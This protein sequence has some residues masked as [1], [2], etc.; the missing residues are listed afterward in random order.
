MDAPMRPRAVLFLL[1]LVVI[2]VPLAGAQAGQTTFLTVQ[3]SDTILGRVVSITAADAGSYSVTITRNMNVKPAKIG[4]TLLDGDIVTL[5]PG[6]FANLQLVDRPDVTM[7]GGG[8]SGLAARISRAGGAPVTGQ[9]TIAATRS[10]KPVLTNCVGTVEV[11]R[12]TYIEG[13]YYI[14]RSQ[15]I[16]P[17]TV[18]ESLMRG[19]MI[20][21]DDPDGKIVIQLDYSDHPD[22][23]GYTL[24]GRTR[25]DLSCSDPAPVRS[26]GMMGEV[27]SVMESVSTTIDDLWTKFKE[28]LRGESFEVQQAIAGGTRG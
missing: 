16:I 1:L 27:E 10:D 2:A 17:A 8:T 3:T 15:R 24:T 9:A 20:A 11:G 21:G 28:L 12:I 26:D 4:D 18:S 6:A 25:F 23:G 14:H 5:V 19:D 13:R 7:L 22:A